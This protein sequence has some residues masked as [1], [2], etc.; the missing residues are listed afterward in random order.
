MIFSNNRAL[1]TL[2]VWIPNGDIAH[3]MDN[4]SWILPRLAHYFV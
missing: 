1:S 3:L 2:C 4:V